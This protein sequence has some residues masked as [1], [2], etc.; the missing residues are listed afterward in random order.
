MLKAF[1]LLGLN[2]YWW[3]MTVFVS[4]L[5][6]Q[7]HKSAIPITKKIMYLLLTALHFWSAAWQQDCFDYKNFSL[8]WV[9]AV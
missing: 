5:T 1:E 6:V 7:L 2:K 9:Y 8:I 4:R 3:K